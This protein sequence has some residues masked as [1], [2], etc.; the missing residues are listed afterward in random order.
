MTVTIIP[1]ERALVVETDDPRVLSTIPG[2]TAFPKRLSASR[3]PYI[4][5]M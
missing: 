5:Q 2:S 4:S 3:H 1:D